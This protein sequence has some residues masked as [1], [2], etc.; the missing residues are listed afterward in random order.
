MTEIGGWFSVK[1]ESSMLRPQTSETLMNTSDRSPHYHADT[2]L[3]PM[4]N[5]TEILMF[6]QQS[7]GLVSRLAVPCKQQSFFKLW[8]H[9]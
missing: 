7:G 5:K 4:T 2:E 3:Y 8:L 9:N 6:Q 1:I